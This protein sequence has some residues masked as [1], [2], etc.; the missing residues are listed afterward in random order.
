MQNGRGAFIE[1]ARLRPARLIGKLIPAA[2]GVDQSG[3][4]AYNS[5]D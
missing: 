3:P 2:A 1:L 5:D 4:V